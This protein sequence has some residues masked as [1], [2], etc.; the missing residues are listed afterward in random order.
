MLCGV[1]QV[2][3]YVRAKFLVVRAMNESICHRIS[4]FFVM[5]WQFG[6][7][8]QR[9]QF[10]M[11]SELPDTFDPEQVMLAPFLKKQHHHGMGPPW[12]IGYL[13]VGFNHKSIRAMLFELVVHRNG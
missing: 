6:F 10:F 3:F 11:R 7:G 8:W 13:N 9:R 4:S 2:A 1:E 12:G 5:G